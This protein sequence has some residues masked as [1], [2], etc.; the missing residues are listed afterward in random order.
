ML[1]DSVVWSAI[2]TSVVGVD[3]HLN[4]HLITNKFVSSEFKGRK[5]G[6]LI[7][8]NLSLSIKY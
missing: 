7:W 2:I 8:N 6:I 3:D 4:E 1:F 5:T